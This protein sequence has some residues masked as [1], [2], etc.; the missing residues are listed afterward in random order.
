V[1]KTAQLSAEIMWCKT[2][3]PPHWTASMRNAR[4][5]IYRNLSKLTTKILGMKGE[6]N[7]KNTRNLF[8]GKI[9]DSS[10]LFSLKHLLILSGF[11][12]LDMYNRDLKV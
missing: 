10:T 5:K 2:S 12:Y 9:F 7:A 8:S 4:Y 3:N 6:N 1:L 11:M